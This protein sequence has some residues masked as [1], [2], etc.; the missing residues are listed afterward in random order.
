MDNFLSAE[1]ILQCGENRLSRKGLHAR[2]PTTLHPSVFRVW[3]K[4]GDRFELR[5]DQGQRIILIAH[6]YGASR[7]GTPTQIT[8]G[9][10][11]D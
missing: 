2:R 11:V 8:L 1:S 10:F 4:N 9:W 7:G 6:Q 3:S 5:I